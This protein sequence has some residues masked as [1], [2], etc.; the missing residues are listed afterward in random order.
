LKILVYSTYFL[1]PVLERELEI[2][3]DHLDRGDEVVI[4]RC[5]GQLRSCLLN[6][7][8]RKSICTYC[9]AKFMRGY[10]VAGVP[11]GCITELPPPPAGNYPELPE[12]F[13][14]IEDFKNF[15]YDDVD[16]GMAA[17]TTLIFH[18]NK[19]H[20]F[21]PRQHAREVANELNMS[22]YVYRTMLEKLRSIKPDAVY[23]FNGRHSTTRPVLRACEKLGI[24]FYA[25]E[26]A[27]TFAKYI[28]RENT[29]P[30]DVEASSREIME[31]WSRG[32]GDREQLGKQFFIN[33][34]N[35]VEQRWF[36][37]VRNQ[38][39]GLLPNG[40]D[41][42][43]KN[44]AIYNSTLYEME[45]MKGFQNR[46]Y[47]DEIDGIRS[48][49]ETFKDDKSIQFYLRLHP[50]LAEKYRHISWENNTQLRMIKEM[51][52]EYDNVVIIP[53]AS[54]VDS[55]AL[56]DNSDVV[57]V[58]GSTMGVEAAYWGRPS[59]LAGAGAAY[60]TLDCCYKPESHEEL[61]E[62]LKSDLEPKD[63]LEAVKYGYW[64]TNRGIPYKKFRQTGVLKGEYMGVKIVPGIFTRLYS[65]LLRAL[66]VRNMRELKEFV[67][68]LKKKF[69][70]N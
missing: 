37:M 58:F 21:N 64:A 34:R 46:I 20:R 1:T 36:S 63:R 50:N 33:K 69:S 11:A 42:S 41:K 13:D 65:Y 3:T 45:G 9:R 40:F 31:T 28:L 62:L 59:I 27:G 23:F 24:T 26:R 18:F 22:M 52:S 44:I 30:H 66:E 57:V 56:L 61:V 43:R 2:I 10:K 12:T 14:D 39:S 5:T 7:R 51:E 4:V 16:L 55:Y 35:R 48:I 47:K 60:R 19:D 15:T 32:D 54:P 67:I 49:L 38:A 6:I 70:R 17:A 29:L 25:H 53:P 68:D 8:H